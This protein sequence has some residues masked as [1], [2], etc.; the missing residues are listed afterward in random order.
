M[1]ERLKKTP[2]LEADDAK[3]QELHPKRGRMSAQR[4]RKPL[5]IAGPALVVAVGAGLWLSGGRYIE[6]D[7]AYVGAN[8]VVVTPE[9]TG[10]VSAVNVHE[11]EHIA[12]GDLLFQI[13]PEPY[14]IARDTANGEVAAAQIQLD[15]LKAS[16]AK[17]QRDIETAQTQV[18]YQQ[19]NFQRISQ[20]AQRNFSAQADLD[21]ARAALNQAE[22]TL[23][24]AQQTGREVLAQLGGDTNMPLEKYPPYMQAKA[25]LDQA[26]RDLRV[27]ELRAPISGV[28]TQSSSLLPGRYLAPGTAALAVVDVDHVWVDANP[29][30]TDL[31]KL[32]AGEVA[33]VTVDAYPDHVF[34]GSLDSISPGTGAQFA[35]LPAQNATGNWVKVVQR[36]PVRIRIDRK[37]DDPVLRAGMSANVSIDTRL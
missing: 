15:A 18:D 34:T 17:A 30:E 10:T 8:T 29:K 31:E 11:G 27:T 33:E 36:V 2:P 7:N 26:E 35:L 13:D 23:A 5:M 12:K 25:K 20:L 21:K 9:V 16:Y 6:T 22:G 24:A 28:V 14:R 19:K 4:L 37:A 1:L 32:K 3:V